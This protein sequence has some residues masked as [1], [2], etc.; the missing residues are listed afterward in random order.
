MEARWISNQTRE[1]M[2][3]SVKEISI[4]LWSNRLPDRWTA[5]TTHLK[6]HAGEIF[7]FPVSSRVR[8]SERRTM[9]SAQA[10]FLLIALVTLMPALAAEQHKGEDLSGRSFGSR[11]L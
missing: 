8:D 5:Q 2:F 7:T 10:Q 9:R 4:K 6:F 3:M 1:R 11:D